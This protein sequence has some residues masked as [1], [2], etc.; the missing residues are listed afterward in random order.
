MP[1]SR[2]LSILRGQAVLYLKIVESSEEAFLL[3]ALV[4]S[5]SGKENFNT[6]LSP[7]LWGWYQYKRAEKLGFDHLFHSG[8]CMCVFLEHLVVCCWLSAA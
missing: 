7:Q 6:Q 3:C 8:K 4:H 2:D 1:H 5:S